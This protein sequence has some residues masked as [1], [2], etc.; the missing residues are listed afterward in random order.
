MMPQYMSVKVRQ[1]T[2]PGTTC[3]TLYE[4]YV[5]S[6]TSHRFITCAKA[7]ETGPM[8]YRPNPRRLWAVLPKIVILKLALFKIVVCST[9]EQSIVFPPLPLRRERE[10]NSHRKHLRERLGA[11]VKFL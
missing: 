11:T 6:L 2:T 10:N 1:T 3:P 5:G 4:K 7:C 9:C 8:I